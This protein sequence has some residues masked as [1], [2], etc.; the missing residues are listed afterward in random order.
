[1]TI[2]KGSSWKL[3]YLSYTKEEYGELC[4]FGGGCDVQADKW[5]EA[6]VSLE[7]D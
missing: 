1:M 3:T 4:V 6:T 7:Q 2:W 5:Q